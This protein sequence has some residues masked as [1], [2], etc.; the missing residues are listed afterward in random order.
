MWIL[1]VSLALGGTIFSSVS[2]K[3]KSDR[4]KLTNVLENTSYPVYLITFPAVTICNNNRIN[5]L[6]IENATRTFLPADASQSEIELFQNF[7]ATLEEFSFGNFELF[8]KFENISLASLDHISMENLSFFLSHERDNIFAKC[9]YINAY[10]FC[11]ETFG[12]TKSES[13]SC[14]SYNSIL[15]EGGQRKAVIQF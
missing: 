14:F 1:I 6:N 10:V 11:N 8:Q 12:K 2:F 3:L 9:W 15:T 7:T 13:G 5:W 4:S